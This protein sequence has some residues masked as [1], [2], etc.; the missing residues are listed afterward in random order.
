MTALPKMMRAIE[1]SKPGGPE[2]LQVC[3]RPVPSPSPDEVLIKTIGAGVNRPDVLQRMGLYKPPS[4]ASDLPGLEVSGEIVGCGKNVQRWRT[5]DL[6]C[7]LTAGGGYADYVCVDA[8]SCMTIPQNVDP[9]N[10]AGLPETVLTVWAN[11]FADAQ[12]R[13]GET[14]L[15]HG[16]TSGIGMT[17]TRMAKGMGANVITSAGSAQKCQAIADIGIADVFLYSEDPW[18][19][20]VTGKDI[21]NVDVVLDMTGGEFVAR[22]LDLLNPGGRHV[23]IAFL[24]GTTAQINVMAIM[25]K[26][27]TISGSTLRPQSLEAKAEYA[28]NVEKNIWPLFSSGPMQTMTDRVFALEEA[29]KAHQYMESGAHIGKI[30]LKA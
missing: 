23:S 29:D 16:G 30:I 4:D 13:A 9:L 26:R 1:I 27:L 24:R 12:L 7:A 14:L 10:A 17:A 3:E 19:S 22:N 21:A 2:V 11:A 28:R 6:V 8:G 18:K 5:G 20:F 25:R 15:V